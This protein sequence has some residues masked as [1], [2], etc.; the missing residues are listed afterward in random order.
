VALRVRVGKACLDV[1]RVVPG[2]CDRVWSLLTDTRRWP[3]WGPSV[4]GVECGERKIGPGSR[5]WVRTPFGARLPFLV[6]DY[7]EQKRWG[8]K[9]AGIRATGHRVESA[10]GGKCRL[11]F[12]V[13]LLAAPY[14]LVCYLAARRIGRIL[15]KELVRESG[16]SP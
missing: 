14:A 7:D 1:A 10:G 13:P 6:T 8:W 3:E 5:G 4:R 11:V 2:P 16:R 15:E 9:V 12:E